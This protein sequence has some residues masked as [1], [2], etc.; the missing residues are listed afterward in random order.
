MRT[1]LL[2]AYYALLLMPDRSDSATQ[3]RFKLYLSS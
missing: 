3:D 2:I 1:Y